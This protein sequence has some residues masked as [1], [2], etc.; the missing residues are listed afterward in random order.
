M[1][2]ATDHQMLPKNF[3]LTQSLSLLIA[4]AYIL[5]AQQD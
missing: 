5:Q 4:K 1:I 2:W 3:L